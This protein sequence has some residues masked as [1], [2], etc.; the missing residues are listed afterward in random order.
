MKKASILLLF[1][2]L[3]TLMGITYNTKNVA[4]YDDWGSI[5][6]ELGQDKVYRASVKNG[7]SRL[8]IDR[9]PPDC[10]SYKLT[11]QREADKYFANNFYITAFAQLRVD[12]NPIHEAAASVSETK[13]ENITFI[14]IGIS[15]SYRLYSELQN[16][17]YISIQ[18]HVDG[19]EQI[20]RFSLN[21]SEAALQRAQRLCGSNDTGYSEPPLLESSS[22]K[23]SWCN[24]KLNQT[25]QVICNNSSLWA[26][27]NRIVEVFKQLRNE[28]STSE[29]KRLIKEQGQWL[30]QQRNIQCLQSV[31]A[32][33]RVYQ[34]R[35]AD[36]ESRLGSFYE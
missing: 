31:S 3:L 18:L 35:I 4:I 6:M 12:T 27:E 10:N 2:L 29:E 36:L 28:S 24:N 34:E 22:Q 26:V 8:I 19:E 23:P 7:N 33:L 14:S 15:E 20:Y 13:G 1:P 30:K 9:E 11:V 21:G 17:N 16:G 32:C 25:E 5:V